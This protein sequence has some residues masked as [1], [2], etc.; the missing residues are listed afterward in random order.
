[1]I[2]SKILPP[3]RSAKGRILPFLMNFFHTYTRAY[4]MIVPCSTTLRKNSIN[5]REYSIDFLQMAWNNFK[6]RTLC[7]FFW[8]EKNYQKELIISLIDRKIVF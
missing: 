2:Q 4:S 3:W 1:M 7:D 8:R 5:I 6:F